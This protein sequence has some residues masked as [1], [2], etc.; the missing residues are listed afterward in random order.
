VITWNELL[1]IELRNSDNAD[2]VRIIEA[3]RDGAFDDVFRVAVTECVEDM[4]AAEYQHE[5]D[6]KHLCDDR[7]W[8][9]LVALCL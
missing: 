3:I 5:D 2:V 4:C 6:G 8:K 9:K 1:D 7:N